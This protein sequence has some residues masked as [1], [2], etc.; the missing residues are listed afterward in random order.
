MLKVETQSLRTVAGIWALV[1][2]L[3]A[4]HSRDSGNAGYV[5]T[6]VSYYADKFSGK[7]TASGEIY[8]HHKLTA[9]HRTLPFGTL[10]EIVNI[11]NGK[12]VVVLV[13]DR[14]SLKPSRQFDLSQAAFRKI[15]DFNKG[16]VK[17]K[18]KVLK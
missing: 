10:V 16:I 5:V 3:Y 15:A 4:C 13:N 8:R 14:G 9:A 2:L 18:F 7:K 17:V 11:D 6:T 1:F 12:S